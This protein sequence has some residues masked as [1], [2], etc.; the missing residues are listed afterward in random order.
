MGVDLAREHL[1]D[2]ILLDLHLPDIAGEEVMTQLREGAPTASIPVIVISAD[3]TAG[4]LSRLMEAGANAQLSK[5]I[6]AM[7][8]IKVIDDL[9]NTNNHGSPRV[10]RT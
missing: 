9:T 8:L 4:R 1:P 7:D 2:L 3:A 6:E 10:D 5:P